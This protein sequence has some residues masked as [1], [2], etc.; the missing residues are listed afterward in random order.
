M[1]TYCKGLCQS[2][3]SFV[4]YIGSQ[5]MIMLNSL[6]L[7]KANFSLIIACGTVIKEILQCVLA[8]IYLQ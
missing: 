4:S 3:N 1:S 6:S 7:A 8:C 2:N 5:L